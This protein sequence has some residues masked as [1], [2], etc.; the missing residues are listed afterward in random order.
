MHIAYL[1]T[2]LRYSLHGLDSDKLNNMTSRETVFYGAIINPVDLD[3]FQALPNGA[4]AIS[5]AGEIAWLEENV[6]SSGLQDVLAKHGWQDAEVT[7][8]ASGEFLI[9]GFVDTHTVRC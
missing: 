1:P 5:S 4:L 8:L 2:V 6:E 9:P 3:S 7:E